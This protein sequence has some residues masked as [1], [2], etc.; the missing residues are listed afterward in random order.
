[1]FHCNQG[2]TS[3]RKNPTTS[4]NTS[5]RI[6]TYKLPPK[7]SSSSSSSSWSTN[8]HYIRQMINPF[9]GA[10]H[11]I[12]WKISALFTGWPSVL[13]QAQYVRITADMVY[14]SC[15][16]KHLRWALKTSARPAT[17]PQFRITARTSPSPSG[18]RWKIAALCFHSATA[19]GGRFTSWIALSCAACKAGSALMAHS[20]M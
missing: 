7:S 15:A 5:Q 9:V 19:E 18:R 4:Y 8:L 20:L 16:Q 10:R 6:T 11:N 1:M 2:S 13:K 17:H 12:K 3:S 14:E